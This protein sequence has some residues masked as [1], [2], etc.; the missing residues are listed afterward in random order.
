MMI[1][2]LSAF[3]ASM[4]GGKTAAS[5]WCKKRHVNFKGMC[6]AEEKAAEV[7]RQMHRYRPLFSELPAEAVTDVVDGSKATVVL[8]R[9]HTRLTLATAPLLLFVHAAVNCRSVI[10]AVRTPRQR[11]DVS[12]VIRGP[13]NKCERK[14]RSALQHL[15][16]HLSVARVKDLEVGLTFPH[17]DGP[18]PHTIMHA[19]QFEKCWRPILLDQEINRVNVV[20]PEYGFELSHPGT[21]NDNV[22]LRPTSS[23]S[24][25][26]LP[27]SFGPTCYVYPTGSERH[28][29]KFNPNLY[30]RVCSEVTAL[31]TW[32]DSGC[33]AINV[34]AMVH[35]IF[36]AQSGEIEDLADDANDRMD[37]IPELAAL[38]AEVKRL[39]RGGEAVN[40]HFIFD[41]VG[42]AEGVLDADVAQRAELIAPYTAKPLDVLRS[43]IA[44]SLGTDPDK[45]HEYLSVQIKQ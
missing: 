17:D 33:D 39:Y 42:D 27:A 7:R 36:G 5:E 45:I 19:A 2:L 15:R 12:Y 41:S 13:A 32:S 3:R 26:L 1:N 9:E 6:E 4:L 31:S 25:L 16:P 37:D 8:R 10:T 22:T 18:Y 34:P 43:L 35:A 38:A 29:S 11:H 14:I 20:V 44:L 24:P 40:D 28:Q 30:T 21:A 23:I